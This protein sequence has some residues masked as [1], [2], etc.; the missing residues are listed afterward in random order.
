MPRSQAR[1]WRKRTHQRIRVLLVTAMLTRSQFFSHRPQKSVCHSVLFR[2]SHFNLFSLGVSKSYRCILLC[3]RMKDC[4]KTTLLDCLS[5][6]FSTIWVFVSLE[7]YPS[8][9]KFLLIGIID[10]VRILG[11]GFL[12]RILSRLNYIRGFLEY[13]LSALPSP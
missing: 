2:P 5:H 6:R 9:W 12:P 7:C 3:F 8:N 1:N 4:Y 11:S 13:F 10:Q